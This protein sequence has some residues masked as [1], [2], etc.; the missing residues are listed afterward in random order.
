[1]NKALARISALS[2]YAVLN[3]GISVKILSDIADNTK[4]FVALPLT[5][6][7]KRHF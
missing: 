3:V 5:E 4:N 6:L 2:K 1:M 7:K